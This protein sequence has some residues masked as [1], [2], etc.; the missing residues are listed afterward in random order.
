MATPDA[1]TS[2]APLPVLFV[3][4]R[5]RRSLDIL[6]S[7]LAGRFGNDFSVKG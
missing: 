5:D 7:D 1:T 6:L 4:D 3:L 2:A